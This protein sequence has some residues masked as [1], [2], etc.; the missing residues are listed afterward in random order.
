[1]NFAM[2]TTSDGSYRAFIPEADVTTPL[3]LVRGPHHHADAD[4]TVI[5]FSSKL[6]TPVAPYYL[7]T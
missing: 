4:A 2:G 1:M 7:T 6:E 5:D 3:T